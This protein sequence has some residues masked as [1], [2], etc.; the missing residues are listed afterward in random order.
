MI[1]HRTVLI[2]RNYDGSSAGAANGSTE[3]ADVATSSAANISA[4]AIGVQNG[5]TTQL[6]PCLR[7]EWC[8]GGLAC[9]QP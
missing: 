5:W 7:A 2:T 1:L 4:G 8:D 9:K 6:R 3:S